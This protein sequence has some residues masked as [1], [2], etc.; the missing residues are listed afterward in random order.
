MV[1]KKGLSKREDILLI[2]EC[3]KESIGL[4]RSIVR[5]SQEEETNNEKIE[6]INEL[7]YS[8]NQMKACICIVNKG[9]NKKGERSRLWYDITC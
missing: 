6:D 8:R 4:S 7:N 1:G 9:E 2:F 5:A 3:K